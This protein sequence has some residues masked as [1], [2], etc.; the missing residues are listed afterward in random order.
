MR[1]Q[2]GDVLLLRMGWVTAFLAGSAERR[3]ELYRERFSSGLSGE[4]DVWEFLWDNRVAAIAA[5]NVA[6]EA[7]ARPGH[8]SLHWAIGRLGITLGELFFLDEL[9]AECAKRSRYEFL[10]VSKPLN[11]RGGIG[12]P[13]NAMAV[14]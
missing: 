10:F 2:P 6:V 11:L 9:S 3:Q 5:D 1:P 14:W 12:S 13:P 7:S 4:E 8:P